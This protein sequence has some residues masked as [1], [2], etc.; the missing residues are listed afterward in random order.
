[1][2]V[3]GVGSSTKMELDVPRPNENRMNFPRWGMRNVV[4]FHFTELVIKNWNEESL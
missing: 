3:R 2:A 4:S 1:M